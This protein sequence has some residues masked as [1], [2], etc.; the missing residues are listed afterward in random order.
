MENGA[1][2]LRIDDH[3][4]QGIVHYFN[5]VW[6]TKSPPSGQPPQMPPVSDVIVQVG[7]PVDVP[8]SALDSSGGPLPLSLAMGP[9]FASL[10]ENAGI[11][12]LRLAPSS[13]DAICAHVKARV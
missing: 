7:N 13:A 3:N 4:T 5:R 9:A 11:Q 2:D 6:I 8:L 12:G 1:S 10:V